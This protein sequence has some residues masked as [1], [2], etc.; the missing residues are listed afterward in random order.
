MI[1]PSRTNE[2]FPFD[3]KSETLIN[4]KVIDSL[5]KDPLEQMAQLFSPGPSYYFVTNGTLEEI[6]FV[7]HN[8]E[9]VLGIPPEEF[10]NKGFSRIL[11]PEDVDSF[12]EKKYIIRDFFDNQKLG[13]DYMKVKAST[14]IRIKSRES[15]YR[16]ILHQVKPF[17][18]NDEESRILKYL[19]IHI[20]VSHMGLVPINSVLF[21][22]LSEEIIKICTKKRRIPKLEGMQRKFTRREME[23]I[24]KLKDGYTHLEFLSDDLGISSKTLSTHIKNMLRKSGCKNLNELIA[25][26]VKE[27]LI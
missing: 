24:K 4:S 8:I 11:H 22:N 10:L 9:T 6:D 2:H 17:I 5:Y 13:F 27:C 3:I 7:N 16:A 14:I 20:D 1:K 23:I 26:C 19:V 18:L 25:Q 12:A 15:N 21:T